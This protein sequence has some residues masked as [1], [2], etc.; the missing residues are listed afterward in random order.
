MITIADELEEAWRE[1]KTRKRVYP[2]WIKRGTL[3]PGVAAKRL[4]VQEAI[5]ARLQRLAAAMSTA[6]TQLVLTGEE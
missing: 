5:V 3:A 4:A 6:P 1:L 2:D